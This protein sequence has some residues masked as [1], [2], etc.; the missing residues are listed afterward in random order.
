MRPIN[1]AVA[2]CVLTF[3]TSCAQ[4]PPRVNARANVLSDFG[5]RVN[6]YV[7]LR[8]R[9]D[10]GAPT[11]K[12]TSDPAG[13]SSAQDTL[14]DRVRAA[15]RGAKRGDIFSPAVAQQFRRLLRPELKEADTQASIREDN[16]GAFP[17]SVNGPYPEGE[18]LSTVPPNV[19]AALP[20]LPQDI[21]YRF[22]G[23]HLILRDSRANLVIDYIP[24][25]LA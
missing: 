16:P 24:N 17:F 11:L 4:N 13:I 15:R 10:K 19:L 18:P 20:Q 22:V 3:V 12:S 8:D 23:K 1:I 14:A 7:E 6:Q 2:L 5:E 21:E 25:V 9:A